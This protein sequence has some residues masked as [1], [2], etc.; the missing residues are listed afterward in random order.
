MVASK[1]F[2]TTQPWLHFIYFLQQSLPLSFTSPITSISKWLN[3]QLCLLHC[4]YFSAKL[5]LHHRGIRID[6][7]WVRLTALGTNLG[8]LKIFL[9]LFILAHQGKKKQQQQQTNNNK[10][11]DKGGGGKARN[12][13]SNVK[14]RNLPAEYITL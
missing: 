9:F 1:G 4:F 2:C 12:K 6:H 14:F 8:L 3:G 11:S 10:R 13:S 5:S 7:N